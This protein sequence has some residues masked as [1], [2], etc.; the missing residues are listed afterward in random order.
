LLEE[1]RDYDDGEDLTF[2]IDLMLAI[3]IAEFR[4]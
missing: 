4:L 3:I 2:N 1:E